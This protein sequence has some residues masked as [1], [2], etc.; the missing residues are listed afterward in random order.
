M[1]TRTSSLLIDGTGYSLMSQHI[2]A[3]REGNCLLYSPQ[4]LATSKT[5]LMIRKTLF[6]E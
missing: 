2:F 4:V 6:S 3:Y 1:V 5:I